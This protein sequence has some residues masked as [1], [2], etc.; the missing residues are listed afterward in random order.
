MVMGVIGKPFPEHDFN[1][2]I[3]LKRVSETCQYKR[4]T[5]NQNFTDCATMNGMLKR[6]EWKLLAVDGMFLGELR[7]SLAEQYG[8]ETDI[9]ERLV[10]KYY[11]PGNDGKRI[12]K[13]IKCEDDPIPAQDR[14]GGYELMARYEKGDDLEKDISCDS[15]F[16]TKVMPMVGQAIRRAYSWV[17]DEEVIYMY[18]DN[19]GGHGTK[20]VV[21]AYVKALAD[22]YNVVCIHQRPRS[23]S[24]NMLDLGAWMALQSIVEKH[25]F[26]Q[27]REVNALWRTVEKGWES[28]EPI[29]LTNIWNRWR[30]VLNL[31][32]EDEG[33]NRL[34]DARRG[35][36]FKLPS[37]NDEELNVE[38]EG[39][40]TPP[41]IENPDE[42]DAPNEG[43]LMEDERMENELMEH[44][45]MEDNPC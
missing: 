27:R 7:A 24:T 28:L 40:G 35:K 26:K 45:L 16:M 34:V 13:Y 44:E 30:L 32:I 38:A 5:C 11:V 6:G 18:L 8:L 19:A 42:D 10:L 3:F 12:P 43:E 37:E 41:S 39:T 15:K 4:M 14:L 33:G 36:L 31:I 22:D 21:D 2:K 23:P 25:H 29:K 9:Q 1:G 20:A 17:P